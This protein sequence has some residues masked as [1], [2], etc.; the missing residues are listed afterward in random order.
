M[1]IYTRLLV[2]PLMFCVLIGCTDP[3]QSSNHSNLTSRLDAARIIQNDH[4]RD[5]ALVGLAKDA[6]IQGDGTLTKRAIDAIRSN[7]IRDEAAANAS[8]LL[9]ESGKSA[10][11]LVVAKLITIN[12]LRD[13]TIGKIVS[14]N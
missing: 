11:A 3:S 9:A 14:G 1:I 12:S 13:Q 8:I 5:A 4:E 2:F 7:A 10:E 6:A